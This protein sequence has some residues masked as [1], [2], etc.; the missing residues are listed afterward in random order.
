MKL[1]N[2]LAIIMDGNGRWAR[3]KGHSRV[4]GHIKGTR[5][6]KKIITECSRMGIKNLTL[7]AFSTENWFRPEAEVTFLMTLLRRYLN[8]EAANLVKENIRFS[9]IGDLG[10]LPEDVK[11]SIQK[12]MVATRDCTGLNLIFAISYGSRQEITKAVRAIAEKVKSGELDC[13]KINS[14][15]IDS[16]LETLGTPDPDLIIRTS[17][18]KRISN[19]LLWQAAYAELYFSDV[20][21]PDFSRLDLQDALE[22]FGSRSRRFGQLDSTDSSENPTNPF[23]TPNEQLLH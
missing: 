10:R 4:F 3:Q 8:R 11:T 14:S 20:L 1:P 22:D 12:T 16:H 13:E 18:E 7:Y 9:V 23:L 17:G 21:W 6:A 5:V 19:F 15:V 2:H